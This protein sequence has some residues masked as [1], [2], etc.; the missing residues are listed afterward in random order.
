MTNKEWEAIQKMKKYEAEVKRAL[1]TMLI[2]KIMQTDYEDLR[3][4]KK[5]EVCTLIRHTHNL[6][7]RIAS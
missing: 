3:D 5:L 1:Y 2:E 6:S 7:N 4:N